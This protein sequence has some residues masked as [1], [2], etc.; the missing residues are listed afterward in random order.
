MCREQTELEKSERWRDEAK[1]LRYALF[2]IFN[3]DDQRRLSEAK[4]IA[5]CAMAGK[6]HGY[7]LKEKQ[8]EK[9]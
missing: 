6:L 7:E 5:Q 9:T 3:L 8:N 1:R 4:R 2:S